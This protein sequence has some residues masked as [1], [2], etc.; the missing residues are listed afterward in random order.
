MAK[1]LNW[2][3]P[4]I[5]A[6]GAG[7]LLLGLGLGL[8]L[9]QDPRGSQPG[10]TSSNQDVTTTAP[11][12]GSGT[13]TAPLDDSKV[14]EPGPALEAALKNAVTLYF[15]CQSL[16]IERFARAFA[17]LSV[18]IAQ[19]APDVSCF[20][21]DAGAA[22]RQWSFQKAWADG[23]GRGDLLMVSL[24]LKIGYA[25]ACL[26]DDQQRL[27]FTDFA[28]AFAFATAGHAM[29]TFV[30]PTFKGQRV[31]RCLNFARECDEP[32]ALA[33]CQQYGYSRMTKWEWVYVPRTV[34]LGDQKTCAGSCGAFTSIICAQ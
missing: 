34:T 4:A 22:S 2:T 31:D 8:F 24:R 11:A 25:L 19:Y 33:W 10:Q 30:N 7:A 18:V 15:T 16:P 13:P 21:G 17:T 12:C 32:A 29:Q 26:P 6:A 14:P 27:F 20:K 9:F 3:I 1:R 5:A 23:Q 28:R